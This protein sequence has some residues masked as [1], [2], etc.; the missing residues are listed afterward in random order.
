MKGQRLDADGRVARLESCDWGGRQYVNGEVQC[1]R[2]EKQSLKKE[3]EM[4]IVLP[5]KRKNSFERRITLTFCIQGKRIDPYWLRTG[6]LYVIFISLLDLFFLL[7][8]HVRDP[9]IFL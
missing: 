7:I 5:L 9:Q 1:S 2:F 8:L 4:P 6:T 3:M